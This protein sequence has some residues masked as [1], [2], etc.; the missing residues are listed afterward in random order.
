MNPA[1]SSTRVL[2]LRHA[3]TA[4]PHLWHGAESDVGLSDRGAA[5]ARDLADWFAAERPVAVVT[6]TLRRAV[7]T[8]RPIAERCGVPLR[9][10]FAWHERRVGAMAGTTVSPPHPIWPETVR[11]WMSGE[12]DFA[13]DGSESFAQVRHRVLSLWKRWAEEF[14]GQTYVAVGHGCAIK[15][16]LL[17][18]D[19]GL[20]RWDEFHCPNLAVH[21]LRLLGDRWQVRLA[22]AAAAPAAW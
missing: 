12:H 8:A 11:R 18:L 7:D 9:T 15:V 6:S 19:V 16:L 20:S 4:T 1:A 22:D 3:E 14:A 5:A 17:S 10:E 21:E 13:P 2:L